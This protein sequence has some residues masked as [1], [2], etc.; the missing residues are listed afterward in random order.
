[1][2]DFKDLPQIKLSYETYVDK[3]VLDADYVSAIP[4][5]KK[6]LGWFVAEE[7]QYVCYIVEIKKDVNRK[8]FYFFQKR[9][10][11]FDNSLCSGKFGTILYGS[12]VKQPFVD[13]TNGINKTPTFFVVEDILYYKGTRVTFNNMDKLKLMNQIFSKEIRQVANNSSYIL[14]GLPVMTSIH[15]NEAYTEYL[16]KNLNIHHYQYK[17]FDKNDVYNIMPHCL[18]K[19]TVP[20]S[21]PSSSY[22]PST[23][24]KIMKPRQFSIKDMEPGMGMGTKT[25][26]INSAQEKKHEPIKQKQIQK[27]FQVMEKVF[28]VTPD[29]QNDIYYLHDIETPAC[30]GFEKAY[31]PDY[32]TSVMMNRLFRNIKE[33]ENLDALEESDDE[34]EFEDQN[35]DKFVD[36]KKSYNMLCKYSHKFKKWIPITIV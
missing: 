8:N 27:I 32:S 5:G 3:K 28:K 22:S 34:E 15:E 26:P 14:F 16:D 4:F 17:Y 21:S 19:S 11:S 7:D 35:I 31:I 33:N 29:I 13:K 30:T 36:L 25:K 20:S 12:I 18:E 9:S 23:Q 10:V 24:T 1:M 2:P 6:A